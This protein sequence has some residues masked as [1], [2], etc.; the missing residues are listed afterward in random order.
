MKQR[1]SKRTVPNRPNILSVEVQGS[2]HYFKV[3]SPLWVSKFTKKAGQ[4]MLSAASLLSNGSDNPAVLFSVLKESGSEF[5]AALG[6]F[7]GKSWLHEDLDLESDP[8]L[9]ILEYGESVFE[10]LDDYG[11]SLEDFVVIGGALI[12]AFKERNTVSQEALEKADF[13]SQKKGDSP[14]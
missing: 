2:K 4:Q 7:I 12:A 3:P 10:E 14:S 9:G 1:T 11:Y 13:F 6:F 8:S 5:L